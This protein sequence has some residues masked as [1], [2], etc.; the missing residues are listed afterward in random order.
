MTS[1]RSSGVVLSAAEAE[2]RETE[3]EFLAQVFERLGARYDLDR[4]HWREET[5]PFDI[6]TGSIL[7]QHTS[8][9]NVEK[10]QANLR[11]A[12]V[13]T[14]EAIAT[15]NED[16]LALLVRPVGT[17]LTKARRLQTFKYGILNHCDHPI[18]TS[19]IGF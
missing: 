13:D 12:G 2:A 8:W 15:L 3:A 1:P 10:A 16:E 5:S 11:D 14:M 6:C 17:P 9:A 4:W 7:V 19:K 18:H